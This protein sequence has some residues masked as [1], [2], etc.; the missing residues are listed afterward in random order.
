MRAAAPW[1]LGAVAAYAL[2]FLLDQLGLRMAIEI[3]YLGL[4]AVSFNLLLGYAGLLSF[5]FNAS[6]GIGAP[7]LSAIY[8]GATSASF[9]PAGLAGGPG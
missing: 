7:G 9:N 6:F 4:F 5:G 2:P 8:V 3:L 1:V